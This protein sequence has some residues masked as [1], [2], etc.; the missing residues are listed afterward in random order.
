MADI[1]N[2]QLSLQ[3]SSS[4][5]I[6]GIQEASIDLTLPPAPE[7]GATLSG[8]VTDGTSPIPNAT[9]KLFDSTGT[10]YQHTL[11]DATGAYTLTDIPAGTYSVAA[12]A[13][14][15]RQSDAAGVT[16]TAG[17][18][19]QANLVC[20]PDSTLNLGVIAGILTSND[21]SS[22]AAPL[23]G[24]K[25]TLK[26]ADGSIIAVTYTAADGEFA[27]YDLADGTYTL[28]SVADGYVAIS[29][30]TAVVA[31]GAIVNVTMSMV[32]DSRT[33][34]GTVSGT[35]RNNVGQ[36]VSGCFVGLYEL[37]TVAGVT[38]E[39]LI[40][41]TKTNTAGQYLFGGVLGGSYVVKAKL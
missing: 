11:T 5:D 34:T 12:V 23:D 30:M 8:I 14:G 25:I 21:L 26:G 18:T 39:R 37:T 31:G 28:T 1:I 16:L 27:F 17:T 10:P 22:T 33:Y 3:Y 41:V 35:I 13:D 40:A 19:I 7:T 9:V 6:Q 4:F 20:I 15:Y 38:Q 29:D 2:D 24:A 36:A 32:A